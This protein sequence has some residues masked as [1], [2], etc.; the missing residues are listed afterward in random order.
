[1]KCDTVAVQTFQEETVSTFLGTL[2]IDD[3]LRHLLNTHY[4]LS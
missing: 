3:G 1:M 2:F 4:H